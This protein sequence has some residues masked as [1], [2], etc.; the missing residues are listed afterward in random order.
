MID[1]TINEI[2]RKNNLKQPDGR[3][4]YNYK[5]TEDQLQDIIDAITLNTNTKT[6]EWSALFVIFATEQ[7]KN[8]PQEGHLTWDSICKDITGISIIKEAPNHTKIGLRFWKRNIYKGQGNYN[9]YIETLRFE[10]GIYLNDEIKKLLTETIQLIRNK[11]VEPNFLLGN[12]EYNISKYGYPSVLKQQ[13]FYTLIMDVCIAIEELR[14]KCDANNIEIQKA[15]RD[16][17]PEWQTTMPI[18]L[19]DN[20]LHHI[21]EIIN[22]TQ[23]KANS[24]DELSIKIS[25]NLENDG[26]NYFINT[27]IN[28]KKGLYTSDQIGLNDRT[29]QLI[30][31]DIELY[32]NYEDNSIYLTTLSKTVDGKLSTPGIN[33]FDAPPN[34]ILK[35]WNITALALENGINHKLSLNDIEIIDENSILIFTEKDG[36]WRFKKMAPAKIKE[37]CCL[38]VTLSL[39]DNNTFLP[40][41]NID[42]HYYIYKILQD[43]NI[44]LANSET[45]NIK[46]NQN[47]DN[48]SIIKLFETILPQNGSFDFTR[49]NKNIYL[50]IPK[51]LLFNKNINAYS[52]FKGRIEIKYNTNQWNDIGI[53]PFGK[54]RIRFIEND[55]IIGY[56]N[57]IIFPDD[58]EIKINSK[59]CEIEIHSKYKFDISLMN[60]KIN[61]NGKTILT[62]NYLGDEV[63][64]NLFIHFD[65]N[66]I[67]KIYIPNPK[68]TSTISNS[69]KVII[70]SQSTSMAKLH[71]HCINLFNMNGIIENRTIQLRLKDN[72][73]QALNG[74]EI[75]RKIQIQPYDLLEIPLYKY[76]NDFIALFS[77]TPNTN[78]SVKITIDNGK[79]P[80]LYIN[81]YD[82]NL[83]YSGN[84]EK[85]YTTPFV[86]GLRLKLKALRLDQNIQ[87]KS[88]IN[89]INIDNNGDILNFISE[90]RWL[91][92]ASEDSKE[93]YAPKLII[94]DKLPQYD[95]DFDDSISEISQ[96]CRIDPTRRFEALKKLFDASYNNFSTDL[97]RELYELYQETK[98]L[99][100]NALDVWKGLIKSPKG[101]LTF[102]FS[103]YADEEFITRITNEMGFIWQLIELSTWI[104]TYKIWLDYTSKLPSIHLYAKELK[105]T[106]IKLIR[107][108]KLDCLIE[109]LEN[110]F[111]RLNSNN[112]AFIIQNEINEDINGSQGKL[113]LRTRHP[114][115]IWANYACDYIDRKFNNLPQD[116]KNMIPKINQYFQKPV[117]YLPVIMAYHS[118]K[119]NYINE[120]EI[121]PEI[122]LGFK[123]NM[124]F[125]KIYFDDV[126]SKLQGF[127]IIQ[128]FKNIGF[129]KQVNI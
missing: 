105:D 28:L 89:N 47:N 32:L 100:M 41:G 70:A 90:G 14:V 22:N 101:M 21:L 78:A 8:N 86:H 117:V 88:V 102:L 13:A 29:F 10:A 122:L 96:A 98:H 73:N 19:T 107:S 99:P 79:Q 44:Q 6:K 111:G 7:L 106:K 113:G 80:K 37:N 76:T 33:Q 52:I 129:H 24:I 119:G 2:L 48:N 83:T 91:I 11:D 9:Q 103:N 81:N 4:L 94:N 5:I 57:I 23:N 114:E 38:I 51:I 121:T 115:G 108:L 12:I 116:L 59:T 84:Q 25:S 127:C 109:F 40:I 68:F 63:L 125:D 3:P 92:F 118:V 55:E 15:I 26:S 56:K 1:K 35:E 69:A 18:N 77:L 95:N 87:K 61:H 17:N 53:S 72:V 82:Y 97:W 58:F 34:I 62:P 110:T 43:T 46:L 120:S 75:K 36:Y 20:I 65:K 112:L 16:N 74:I 67:I 60:K 30:Q 42:Q 85:I 124:N 71:N 49:I 104:E 27:T 39:N 123:M 126:F 50:G 31:G 54:K 45:F 93:S 64:I 128:Y 66:Q